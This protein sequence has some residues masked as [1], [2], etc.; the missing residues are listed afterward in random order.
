[1]SS[2]EQLC[3]PHSLNLQKFALEFMQS[4]GG[5]GNENL[6]LTAGVC[7]VYG[8]TA[9]LSGKLEQLVSWNED[10]PGVFDVSLL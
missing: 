7:D 2:T 1:M 4:E 5:P 3:V 6:D 10:P 8:L 9:G